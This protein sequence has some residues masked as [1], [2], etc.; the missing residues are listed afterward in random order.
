MNR[1]DFGQENAS[2]VR[3]PG[4]R[5]SCDRQHMENLGVHVLPLYEKHYSKMLP[6]LVIQVTADK[7]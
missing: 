5:E 2:G 7:S 1:I 4:Q 3:H 6:N